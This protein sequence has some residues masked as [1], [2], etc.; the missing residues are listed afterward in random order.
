[1]NLELKFSKKGRRSSLKKYKNK[2]DRI[3]SKFI[4]LRDSKNGIG[5]CI[6]CGKL[7]NWT[8]AHCG[9]F[10]PRTRLATRFNEQNCNLQCPRCN[11]FSEGEH[12]I[13]G[14]MLNQKYGLGTAD[15]LYV[16][17]KVVVKFT[18]FDYEKMFEYYSQKV[19]E[20]SPPLHR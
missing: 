7:I 19:A 16:A 17:S 2:L 4:R 18:Q 3:F 12:Y 11:T 15:K 5:R 13:Y 9:H 10:M 1:M 14:K 6:T 8:K 20:I